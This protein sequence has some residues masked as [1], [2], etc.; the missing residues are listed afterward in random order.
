M[1]AVP[2]PACFLIP[3]AIWRSA[4]PDGFETLIEALEAKKA[5]EPAAGV[6]DTNRVGTRRNDMPDVVVEK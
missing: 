4:G 1:T 6:P 5:R 2:L 3:P